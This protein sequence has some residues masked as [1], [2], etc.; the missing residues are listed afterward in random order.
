MRAEEDI[1]LVMV[2]EGRGGEFNE[3]L[4]LIKTEN[5]LDKIYV[6]ITR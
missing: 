5:K 2:H 6:I 1:T 4:I 3:E